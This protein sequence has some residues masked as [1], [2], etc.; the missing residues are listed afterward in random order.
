MPQVGVSGVSITGFN[1]Y[2]VKKLID[3]DFEPLVSDTQT[4]Y[5]RAIT[6]EHL[7]E[8]V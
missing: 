7:L 6:I 5:R 4:I 8:Q 2:S 1:I 3:F